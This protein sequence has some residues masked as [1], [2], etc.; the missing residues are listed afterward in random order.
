MF[1]R[2]NRVSLIFSAFEAGGLELVN[3]SLSLLSVTS[4]RGPLKWDG[5]PIVVG[6]ST[7]SGTRQIRE[8]SAVKGKNSLCV[9]KCY[10]GQ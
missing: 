10:L 8:L 6:W 2:K 5:S 7:V 4:N 3:L 9:F 1:F